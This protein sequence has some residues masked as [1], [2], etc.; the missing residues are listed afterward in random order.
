MQGMGGGQPERAFAGEGPLAAWNPQPLGNQPALGS[1]K[2]LVS[3]APPPYSHHPAPVQTLSP[4][5]FELGSGVQTT[6]LPAG[7]CQPQSRCSHKHSGRGPTRPVVV[8][9][10]I[11]G[12]CGL[13]MGR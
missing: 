7:G 2:Q 5:S 9:V 1:W 3:P 11:C 10:I 13:E 12:V 8:V 6:I 4:G